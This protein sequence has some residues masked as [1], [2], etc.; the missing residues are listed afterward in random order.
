MRTKV[1]RQIVLDFNLN[2]LIIKKAAEEGKSVSSFINDVL[3]NYMIKPTDK[4]K[5]LINEN[6]ALK[7]LL[8]RLF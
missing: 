8:E 6:P 2:E 5:E 4:E 3:W 1:N 7:A